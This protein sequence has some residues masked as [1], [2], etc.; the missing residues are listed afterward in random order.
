MELAIKGF[1]TADRLKEVLALLEAGTGVSCYFDGKLRLI[2]K[3]GEALGAGDM[4]ASTGLDEHESLDEEDRWDGPLPAYL[5]GVVDNSPEEIERRR[6]LKAERERDARRRVEQATTKERVTR[7]HR[8]DKEMF[9]RLLARYGQPLIDAINAEI[10]AVWDE[11]KPVF[12]HACKDGKAGQ[13]R[14]MPQLELRG[15]VVSFHGFNASGSTKRVST[16][17]SMPDGMLG[18]TPVW[19]Y[20]E[21]VEHSVPRIR[22]VIEQYA[23]KAHLVRVGDTLRSS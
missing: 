5:G 17:V 12:G 10:A 7:D 20:K 15:E 18:A 2:T 4:V 19:K 3:A 23:E 6:L 13:S 16:P 21:W 8:T 9:G 11:V 14:L 1:V 22:A